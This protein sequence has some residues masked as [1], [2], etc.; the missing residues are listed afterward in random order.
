V[1]VNG[2]V[3]VAWSVVLP[4]EIVSP[5]EPVMK[6]LTFTPA[7]ERRRRSVPNVPRE[8]TPFRSATELVPE[9]SM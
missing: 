2:P 1:E 5:F 7:P 4:E 3:D 8:M 6:P 9:M